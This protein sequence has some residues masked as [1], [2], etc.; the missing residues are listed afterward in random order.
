MQKKWSQWWHLRLQQQTVITERLSSPSLTSS[1]SKLGFIWHIHK[2]KISVDKHVF[3][4]LWNLAVKA[5][6]RTQITSGDQQKVCLLI[7]KPTG[8]IIFLVLDQVDRNRSS[9]LASLFTPSCKQVLQQIPN[10]KRARFGFP[11]GSSSGTLLS[12]HSS[13]MLWCTS[14]SC[15]CM[16]TCYWSTSSH[17]PLKALPFLSICCISGCSRWSA[18]RFER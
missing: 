16:P 13:A 18:R 7:L 8:I 11:A 1:T 15:F 3:I 5:I 2:Y 12:L 14:S 9:L 10:P 4:F 17:L 6:T